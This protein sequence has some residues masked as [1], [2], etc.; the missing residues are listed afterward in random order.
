MDQRMLAKLKTTTIEELIKSINLVIEKELSIIALSDN[1]VKWNA[2]PKLLL[3][4]EENKKKVLSFIE[5]IN[6]ISISIE[7]KI[8][9]V[10]SLCGLLEFGKIS[11]RNYDIGNLF[12]MVDY[13][14]NRS[15][16][17]IRAT[18]L[19]VGNPKLLSVVRIKTLDLEERRNL[20]FSVIKYMKEH[21]I[22]IQNKIE[23]KR[24]LEDR[25]LEINQKEL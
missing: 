18:I 6:T 19:M 7:E 17:E 1:I 15:I 9:Y 21:E 10:I 13:Y 8:G 16:T 25:I 23:L 11:L 12:T 24:F 22:V 14:R 20:L 5:F 4:E 3:L 2:M